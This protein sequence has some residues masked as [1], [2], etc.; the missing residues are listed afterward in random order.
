V[1]GVGSLDVELGVSVEDEV[2]VARLDDAADD[3]ADVELLRA[4]LVVSLG[5]ALD[6]DA[7]LV[8]GNTTAEG[9]LS[10]VGVW[11]VQSALGI[12]FV[13][14]CPGTKS[15]AVGGEIFAVDRRRAARDSPG[16]CAGGAPRRA[17]GR[18]ASTCRAQP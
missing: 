1:D 8:L 18:R 17:G 2:E 6:D 5:A 11:T 16:R 9:G 14:I 7:L 13:R 12:G 15:A 3:R 4:L 10:S